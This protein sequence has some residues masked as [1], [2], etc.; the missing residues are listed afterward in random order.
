MPWVRFEDTFYDH[1]KVLAASLQAVGLHVT[2]ICYSN[3]RLTDGRISRPILRALRGTAKLAAELVSVGLWEASEDGW[4][5][6]DF[7]DYNPSRDVT[8]AHR[9]RVS[10][11]RA[12][13][14]QLGGIASA[15]AKQRASKPIANGQQEGSPYPSR[16][17]PVP[18]PTLSS[19]KSVRGGSLEKAGHVLQDLIG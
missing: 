6:H 16:S 3:A 7:L 1:P 2:A 11:D 19:K 5:I 4:R 15:I 8:V 17:L 9:A 12:R 13:A 18:V 14:G 10:E